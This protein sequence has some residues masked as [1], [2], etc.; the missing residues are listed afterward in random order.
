MAKEKKKV[1]GL[2]GSSLADISFTLLIFFLVTT[3][4]NTDRGLKTV[5]PE[6][7]DPNQEQDAKIKEHNIMIISVNMYDKIMCTVGKV[8]KKEISDVSEIRELAK[9]F[10]DN[11]KN[12]A[13]LPDRWPVDLPEPFG[14]TMI[15]KNHVISL[16]TDRGTSYDVYFNVYN[17]LK[18][19]YNELRNDLAKKTFGRTYEQC[20]ED[21]QL[22]IRQFYPAK[23]SEA[24]PKVYNQGGN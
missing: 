5:L 22:A 24:E 13:G 18:A 1:P 8:E 10:I 21:Q 6:P 16:Q 14:T 12:E 3:S 4:M 7:P 15:T 11:P 17:E 19:A 9:M 20:D 2:N 23:I